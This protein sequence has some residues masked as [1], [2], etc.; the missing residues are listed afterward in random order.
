MQYLYA[1]LIKSE[2]LF[3]SL[4]EVAR[5]LKGRWRKKK[6][7][8]GFYRSLIPCQKDCLFC[9]KQHYVKRIK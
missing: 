1:G 3:N 4:W 5:Y 8:F 6:F 9:L 7:P 2:K